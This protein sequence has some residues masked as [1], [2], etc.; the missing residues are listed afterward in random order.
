MPKLQS[1]S[2]NCAR[3]E[4]KGKWIRDNQF[5]IPLY[6]NVQ[7][8]DGYRDSGADISLVCREIVRVNDYIPIKVSKF[9][10]I[11]GV[12]AKFHWL[13]CLENLSRFSTN[14][15]FEIL[16]GVLE[17]LRLADFLLGKDL[18]SVGSKLMASIAVVNLDGFQSVNAQ[19]HTISDSWVII[20]VKQ[21]SATSTESVSEQMSATSGESVSN[22]I[23][24]ATFS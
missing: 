5:V 13:K 11:K 18:F 6:A 22:Q 1:K 10:A 16:V 3:V 17:D 2:N 19:K 14:K 23:L 24:S 15:N 7:L 9:K 12:L 8:V 21:M 4:L 20:G